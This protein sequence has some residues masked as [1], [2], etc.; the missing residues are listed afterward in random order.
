MSAM[1]IWL[2]LVVP[3]QAGDNAL[4]Y[5]VESFAG[6]NVAAVVRLNLVAGIDPKAMGAQVAKLA[7]APEAD[8]VAA[9]FARW[10]GAIRAAGARELDV[11]IEPSALPGLPTVLVPLGEG[12]LAEPIAKA[13]RSTPPLVWPEVATIRGAVVG[14]TPE[15]IARLKAAPAAKNPAYAAARAAVMDAPVSVVLIPTD[16]MRRVFEETMPNLPPQLGG[17]PVTTLT[18]GLTWAALRADFGASPTL[19]LVAQ[20]SDPKAAGAVADV[21][22]GALAAVRQALGA[23]PEAKDLAAQLADVQPAVEGDRVRLEADLGRVSALVAVPLQMA[24]G[25]A[26]QAQCVNSLRQIALAMHIHH[27]AKKTFPPAFLAAKD[28]TPLLSWRVAILPYIDQEALYDEFKLDEPWDS[29]HNKALLPR[30]PAIYRCPSSG[31][32]GGMTTYLVPRGERTLFPG[33]TGVSV[34]DV[35]DGTAFTIM[36]VDAGDA[37]AVPW[38]KPEDWEVGDPWANRDFPGIDALLGH[39]G[40]GLPTAFAD[41]SVKVLR[42]SINVPVLKALLTRNGGEAI[43]PG[44]F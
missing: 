43:S 16:A 30:M 21:A 32:G 34:R 12:T 41:G 10:V 25:D 13:L 17:G 2:A 40:D 27:D 14:G 29:P 19:K 15:A 24:R 31:T 22:R 39:H 7:D 4:P 36:V 6:E 3:A 28:G 26:R 18:R 11:L 20:A 9:E 23:M 5:I 35:T 8:A 38:T 33:A 1:L 44:K 42:K 37:K